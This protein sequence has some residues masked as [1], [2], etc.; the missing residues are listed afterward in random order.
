MC[1]KAYGGSLT[2]FNG[3]RYEGDG[4]AV[5]LWYKYHGRQLGDA[6]FGIV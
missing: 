2:D 1:G 6:G 4:V 5:L 3:L